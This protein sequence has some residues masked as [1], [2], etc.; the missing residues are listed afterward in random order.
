M[1]SDTAGPAIVASSGTVVGTSFTNGFTHILPGGLDHT[2]FI[3]GL[4]F[5]TRN[6]GTLLLQ[7]T[8]FTLAH[9]LAL[10]LSLHGVVSL[11]TPV[12][13][14]AI[15]A[16]I[17]FVAIENLFAMKLGKA[18]LAV[19]VA[20]GLVHGLGFAHSFEGTAV[21]QGDFLPA[22]F[23]YN[24]GIE[25]GQIAL[26]LLAYVAV[27]PW[28]KNPRYQAVVARPASILIALCGFYWVVDWSFLR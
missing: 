28:W 11:P 16:G 17:A 12:V 26:V 19:I 23:S 5:L 25:V 8:L 7:M 20:S 2:L 27:W 18:R 10:G 6:F 22:L 15:G 3:L 9:S 1:I 14:V 24:L 13:N 21:E 4:F